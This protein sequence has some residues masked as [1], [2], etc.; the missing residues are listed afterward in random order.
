MLRKLLVAL[1]C[2]V[3]AACGRQPDTQTLRTD[4]ARQLDETY[5]QGVF[6]IVKVA[7]KGA[8]VD[9]TAPEGENRR[10]VYYDLVLEFDKDFTLD[11]WD[12]PG[13]ASLVT[14]LGAGPRSI[15][16][17]KSGGNQ[18]GD[19]IMAHASAI[20]RQTDQG[21]WQVVVAPGVS[22]AQA[23][24]ID[25][26]ATQ[27]VARRLLT[28]LDEISRS[29]ARSGSSGGERIVQQEL[30]RSVARING[31]LSRMQ[32]GYP[33]AGGPDRGEYVAFARALAAS[34]EQ[35]Q[36]RITPLITGGGVDNI[37]M[38]RNGDAVLALAQADTALM[39][40][41]GSGPF[42]A[43]GAFTRL[44]AIGGLYPELVH[45]V[46]RNERAY[47]SVRDLRGK[48]I[49]LGPKGSAV[50]AT[51]E[52]VLAAHGLE[53]GN[54]YVTVDMPFAAS[55]PALTSGRIDATVHVIGVPAT[56]LR[57]ALARAPLKLL[58]L[59]SRAIESLVN[60]EPALMSINIAQGVYP[61][62]ARS[63]A[64]LGMAALLLTTSDLTRDEAVE[65][66]NRVYKNGYDLLAF[67]SA[68]GAQVSA[69]SARMGVTIPLH[70]GADEALGL[71]DG[72]AA[73]VI[74]QN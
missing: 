23:P 71:L 22:G 68:Q 53:A 56:P 54:D 55:L 5:G 31:R 66:V 1:F 47:Q 61:N 42:Y 4:V 69:A 50:R 58:P 72:P 12:R 40:Y 2:V 73:Q 32:Q 46:V 17:V 34:A 29:V 7:R 16:G 27:P 15:T 21:A 25:T 35:G 51:L 60:E 14:L 65:L 13:V 24:A 74:H 11:A 18:A 37:E 38:L 30:E 6:D 8:A 64:S 62:Q 33:L 44:R 45:I 49:A 57:D 70:E 20:Y 9:S 48:K 63:V 39:A 19:Q 59:D 41:Q 52:R 43:K 28:T 3:L 36:A 67:G 10:V 26:G